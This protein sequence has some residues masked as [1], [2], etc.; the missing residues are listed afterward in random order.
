MQPKGNE[1]RTMSIPTRRQ[2]AGFM[3]QGTTPKKGKGEF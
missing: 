2:S 3:S 1:E